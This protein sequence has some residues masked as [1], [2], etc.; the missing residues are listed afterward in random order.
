MKLEE[1]IRTGLS[2]V[3]TIRVVRTALNPLLWL[4]GLTTPAAFILAAFIGDQ[5]IR[6]IWLCFAAIPVVATLVAYVIFMF[7]DPDRLQSEE[8]RIRQRALQILYKKGGSTEIV[9]VANQVT[10]IEGLA[11]SAGRWR[12][13]M[14]TYLLVFDDGSN[15][16][17]DLRSFVETLD[18]GASMYTLDGHVCFLKSK[19]SVSELSSMFSKFCGS[20]LFFV[21]DLTASEYEG[22]MLGMFWDFLKEDAL[23]SAAE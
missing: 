18:S 12:E 22:R 9:D 20:S 5:L 1:I 10:R 19:L 11:P 23:Q 16:E 2:R 13:R 15:P 3:D 21:A 7:R 6:L 17:I 4:V 8:Y 14:K